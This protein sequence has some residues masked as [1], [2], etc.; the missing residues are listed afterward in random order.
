MRG[1]RCSIVTLFIDLFF[2][3]FWDAFV[4]FFFLGDD[5]VSLISVES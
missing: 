1:D 2:P 4:F 3:V 5:Y